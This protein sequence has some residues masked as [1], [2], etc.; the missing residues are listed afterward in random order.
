[1]GCSSLPFEQGTLG[2]SVEGV[3]PLS[4]LTEDTKGA[5]SAP[6]LCEASAPFPY[7]LIRWH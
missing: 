1:M 6:I 3:C 7:L 2:M 4:S 5:T